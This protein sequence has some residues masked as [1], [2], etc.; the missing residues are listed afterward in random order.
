MKK[1]RSLTSKFC[2]QHGPENQNQRHEVVR[3]KRGTLSKVT[4]QKSELATVFLQKFS[5]L[6]SFRETR[7][8]Y[9][10]SYTEEIGADVA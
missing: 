10:V 5:N 6:V 9:L 2:L 7:A 8:S 3:N 4:F 1:L